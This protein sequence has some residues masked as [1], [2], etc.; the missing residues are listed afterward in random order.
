MPANSA[1]MFVSPAATRVTS[2]FSLIVATFSSE[3]LYFTLSLLALARVGNRLSALPI[4]A[5]LDAV[6][7]ERPAG[8]LA[9]P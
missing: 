1:V 5:V 3:L 6:P 4:V 8:F 2:P 7:Q 9:T